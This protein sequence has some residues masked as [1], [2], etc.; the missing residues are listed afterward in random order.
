[1]FS[2]Q[3]QR[4]RS[5]EIRCGM[6]VVSRIG[7]HCTGA[8]SVRVVGGTYYCKRCGRPLG[9]EILTPGF[10]DMSDLSRSVSDGAGGNVRAEGDALRSRVSELEASLA[11]ASEE[12]G[13]T[14]SRLNGRISELS[15]DVSDLESRLR[16]SSE[17]EKALTAANADLED[18]LRHV[19]A[20]LRRAGS[21]DV[22]GI[23]EKFLCFAAEAENAAWDRDDPESIRRSISMQLDR[24]CLGLPAHGITIRRHRR[25]EPV[26]E[27]R[28]DAIF[29]GTPEA[30]RDMTVACTDRFG[31]SFD[32]GVYAD[33]PEN[34]TVYRYTGVPSFP[35]S[36][37]TVTEA[38]SD[39]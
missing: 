29:E 7:C 10:R 32:G 11:S 35:Q 15:Q 21:V 30:P 13:R 38:G 12:H 27:G 6:F 22:R 19:H 9:I 37:S 20:E 1:M 33:I 4:S 23:V 2:G 24:L 3:S 36:D 25:G 14:V 26:G 28:L 8:P 39:E 5:E 16:D 31:C 34:V 18:S 17:R